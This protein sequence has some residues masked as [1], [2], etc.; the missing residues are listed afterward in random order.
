M[1]F[2]G[3]GVS[4]ARLRRPRPAT[5]TTATELTR[6]TLLADFCN[7]RETRAHPKVIRHP[8]RP[9]GC[10]SADALLREACRFTGRAEAL[11]REAVP[12]VRARAWLHG[13]PEQTGHEHPMSRP[14]AAGR[15]GGAGRSQSRQG[16]RCPP[17][18]TD[19][20]RLGPGCLP[21]AGSETQG[22]TPVRSPRGASRRI[23]R[24]RDEPPSTKPGHTRTAPALA[25]GGSATSPNDAR[26]SVPAT[27][28]ETC[29]PRADV[30]RASTQ[31]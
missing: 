3:R 9:N 20:P 18:R 19:E 14:L 17:A 16:C 30:P 31:P 21:A 25:R 7:R 10:P 11:T 29:H 27:F 15:R 23:L 28:Y 4:R 13:G 5:A 6:R 12:V 2:T 1:P 24:S 26:C 22:A 8:A